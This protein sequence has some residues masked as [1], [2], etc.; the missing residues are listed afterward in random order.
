MSAAERG[1]SK[2]KRL[3]RSERV[4]F[5]GF[6]ALAFWAL[7]IAR[8]HDFDYFLAGVF[9]LPLVIDVV[10][11]PWLRSRCLP[12]W[13]ADEAYINRLRRWLRSRSS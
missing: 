13:R 7:V 6:F 2:R 4:L 10:A 9:T 12:E 3:S 1:D 11:R 8:G 5:D